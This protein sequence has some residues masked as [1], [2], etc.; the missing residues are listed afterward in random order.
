MRELK[1]YWSTSLQ[2]GRKNFGDWLSPVLC[3][4]LSGMRIVYAR[5][6]KCDL[7][8]LGSILSKAKNRFWNRKIHIWGSGLIEAVKPFTSPHQIHAVRGWRTAACLRNQRPTVVGDPGLLCGMLVPPGIAGHKKWRV[9]L[10]PHYVDQTNPQIRQFAANQG[11]R[12]IDVFS[13]TLDF[14]REVAACEVVLSSSLHGLI[15]ADALGV[16]NAWMRLSDKV[17]GDDF[18]Y[19]DYYSVFGIE[20]VRPF[21]F[22]ARTE[23]ADVLKLVEDYRR[24][25][26]A[27]RQHALALT[28]PF[29]RDAI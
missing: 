6:N 18:K 12:I 9:G 23:P 22:E 4:A 25:G 14:I 5:P 7:M 10:I 1:L 19:H 3:E 2:N 16:P 20:G 15:T 17:W 26:L 28:F 11:V 13:E 29:R 27:D 24:P 21:P 8:A